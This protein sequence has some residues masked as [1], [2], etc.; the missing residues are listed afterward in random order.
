M[1]N[2]IVA[3][4]ENSSEKEMHGDFNNKYYPNFIDEA[5]LTHS[6][7]EKS[8]NKANSSD[9]QGISTNQSNLSNNKNNSK[10]FDADET[11]KWILNNPMCEVNFQ[12]GKTSK[13]NEE[14]KPLDVKL[15]SLHSMTRNK[16][17]VLNPTEPMDWLIESKT[18]C[19]SNL[20]NTPKNPYFE[21]CILSARNYSYSPN[22]KLSNSKSTTLKSTT[23]MK[24]HNWGNTSAHKMGTVS[25][26]K[27]PNTLPRAMKKLKE[28][29]YLPCDLPV[30]HFQ[31]SPR[32]DNQNK[33]VFNNHRLHRCN[34]PSHFIGVNQPIQLPAMRL[35][36]SQTRHN[37]VNPAMKLTPSQTR[38]NRVNPTMKL[39][40]S[41][42]RHSNR[43]NPTMRLTPS[44][45]RHSGIDGSSSAK[46]KQSLNRLQAY[47]RDTIKTLEI[48]TA[49]KY[50]Q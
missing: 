26:T 45:T 44:Q 36:P 33:M 16:L 6:T 27:M 35:T 15:G 48:S 13:N 40:P 30:E 43:I 38:H 17:Y 31:L 34:T 12:Y 41:Q 39:T 18:S 8:L 2:M 25:H 9:I 14:T 37:R 4:N 20:N 11:R 10:R 50:D 32:N 7:V 19:K 46:R 22:L 23:P 42:T 28:F 3:Q 49:S 21:P 5:I 1:E 24:Q 47:I 29:E